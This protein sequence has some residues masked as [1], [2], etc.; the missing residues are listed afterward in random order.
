MVG[1]GDVAH[2]ALVECAVSKAIVTK[3]KPV[4]TTRVKFVFIIELSLKTKGPKGHD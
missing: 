2:W 1:V 3:T 4:T